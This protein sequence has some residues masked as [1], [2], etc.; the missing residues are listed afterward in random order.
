MKSC[1]FYWVV[2]LWCLT[3]LSIIF[4]LPVYHGRQ[5]Y[6]WRKPE[7]LEKTSDLSQVTDKLYYIMLYRV[8]LAMTG[9][10]LTTL[11]VIC[12]ECS[13]SCKSNYYTITTMT[14]CFAYAYFESLYEYY[15]YKTLEENYWLAVL[16]AYCWNLWEKVFCWQISDFELILDWLQNVNITL[17]KVHTLHVWY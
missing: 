17:I 12:T 9:F 8:H 2:G 4:Q 14:V 15:R 16:S 13:G 11:V 5:F 10:E 7:Y 1:I 3:P 6:W